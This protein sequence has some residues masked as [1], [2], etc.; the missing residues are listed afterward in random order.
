MEPLNGG[1]HNSPS[2]TCRSITEIALLDFPDRSYEVLYA[3]RDAYCSFIE[4]FGRAAG[5]RVITTTALKAHSIA[6]LKAKRPL[7]LIDLTQPGAL[8][9]IGA[10]GN[11][12]SGRRRRGPSGPSRAPTPCSKFP[13]N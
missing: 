4:T 7:R 1:I 13:D 6:E 8:V 2:T 3:G 11:L 12:F 9:R 10:D 5:T